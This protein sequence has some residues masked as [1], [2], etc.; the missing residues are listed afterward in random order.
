MPLNKETKPN[1]PKVRQDICFSV[2]LHSM[3][4][5]S[6]VV[7]QNAIRNFFIDLVNIF[8]GN[9]NFYS[10]GNEWKLDDFF[11]GYLA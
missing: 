8:E 5:V 1:L 6:H 11:V 7:T 10:V 2:I 9:F 4:H 3:K